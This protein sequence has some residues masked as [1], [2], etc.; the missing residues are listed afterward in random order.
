MPKT[1]KTTEAQ[2]L[3]GLV[4]LQEQGGTAWGNVKRSNAAF[5]QHLAELYFWWRAA[6]A[7]DGFLQ[8]KYALLNRKF[9][10]VKYGTNYGALFWLVWG[11]NNCTHNEADR[12]SRAFNKIHAE[13]ERRPRYYAKDGVERLKAFIE[14]NN[15]VYG[16]VDYGKRSDEDEDEIPV[17]SGSTVSDAT[18]RAAIYSAAKS[19]YANRTTPTIT[20][21]NTLPITDDAYGVILIKKTAAGY[22]LVGASNDT[23]IVQALLVQNYGYEFA[24]LPN[25]TRCLIETIRTQVLPPSIIKL[26]RDLT[27]RAAQKHEDKTSKLATRRLLYRAD[28]NEFLLSAVRVR[29]SVVT[30]AKP[31]APIMQQLDADVVLSHRAKRLLELKAVSGHN[32]NM[33]RADSTDMLRVNTRH[34]GA[35]YITRMQ[36]IADENDFFYLDFWQYDEGT[37]VVW[38][39]DVDATE[40]RDAYWQHTLELD[41]FKQLTLDVLDKWFA[42]HAL[43]IK[44]PQGKLCMLELGQTEATVNLVYKDTDFELMKTVA[45]PNSTAKHR[46]ASAYFL[47]KDLM[48]VLRSVADYDIT[49][50][51]DM[52]LHASA[53]VIKFATA[54]ASYT[55]YVPTTNANGV[56]NA[57]AFVTYEPAT[58]VTY[59]TDEE[60]DYEL[61]VAEMLAAG[62][63]QQ[64]K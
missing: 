49:G 7:V 59:D 38:Q 1:A 51:V 48:P 16:L 8:S 31:I 5:Y 19:F 41:W 58:A 37:N 39:A 43:Y 35:S 25:A 60:Y 47:T 2:L 34:D 17:T 13:Y 61:E 4:A 32:F 26:Q 11:S 45:F 14:L 29:C 22:S 57:D 63:A 52:A 9:K 42:T 46:R 10:Q 23:N 64:T 33:Y 62:T 36:N 30:I 21:A 27:D 15:G 50:A 6:N 18:L 12:H 56:R 40:L 54:A 20:I 53:L 28:R 24:A 44:R 3:T 55:I